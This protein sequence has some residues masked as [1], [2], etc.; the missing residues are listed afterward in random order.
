MPSS[1]FVRTMITRKQ[2]AVANRPWKS[3]P[4][5]IKW[6]DE[7]PT[8]IFDDR[9]VSADA[10]EP[11]QKVT[12][13]DYTDSERHQHLLLAFDSGRGVKGTISSTAHDTHD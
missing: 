13:A 12:L 7:P 10:N 6:E 9:T 8:L 2:S 11:P 5:A 1:P 3:R 4:Q